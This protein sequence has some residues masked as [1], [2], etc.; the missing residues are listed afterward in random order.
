MARGLLIVTTLMLVF[1]TGC[2][3]QQLVKHDN[4]VIVE[5]LFSVWGSWVK[6]KRK[7]VDVR[8]H[9][10]NDADTAIVIHRRDLHCSKGR[11]WGR[12]HLLSLPDRMSAI[13]L[14][15]RHAID[16][17]AVCRLPRATRGDFR[18]LISHVF[19]APRR[20]HRTRR[21]HRRRAP[22]GELLATDIEWVLFSDLFR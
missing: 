21:T 10:A 9:I 4:A 1:A 12:L 8:F 16:I 2:R 17:T 15:P 19:E 14:R 22:H 20:G 13:L 18:I 7:R 5:G 3:R 11:R 6:N